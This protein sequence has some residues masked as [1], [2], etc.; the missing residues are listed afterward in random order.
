M[1]NEFLEALGSNNANN[2][3]IYHC[4]VDLLEIGRLQ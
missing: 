1:K 4:I 2:N 3:Q